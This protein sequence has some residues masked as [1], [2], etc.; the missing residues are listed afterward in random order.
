[1][2]DTDEFVIT[3][4]ERAK[5]GDSAAFADLY[6]AYVAPIFRYVFTRV[7]NRQDAEDIT[8][9]VFVK[10]WTALGRYEE[11]GMPF[12]AWLYRIAHNSTIDH[13][14][15]KKD[16]ILDEPE[17]LEAF[18]ASDDSDPHEYAKATERARFVERALSLVPETQQEMLTLRFIEGY[19]TKEIARKTGKSED[20][21][22]QIQSRALR[23]LRNQLQ[24]YD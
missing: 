9:S 2:S 8:Q 7:R 21:V 14:K 10:A 3:L 6:S 23:A 18:P 22:R 4:V 19:S 17:A 20:A 24:Q 1:M 16:I 11:R 15:K 5:A 12:G 13:Y